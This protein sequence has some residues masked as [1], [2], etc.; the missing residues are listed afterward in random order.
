[1]QG[2]HRRWGRRA[3][4]TVVVSALLAPG[5]AK[6][7]NT[8]C[9]ASG[10]VYTCTG[11]QSAG[12]TMP[13]SVPS[14]AT[15]VTVKSLTS[16][17]SA[18][19]IFTQPSNNSN[20]FLYYTVPYSTAY[21]Y[22][23]AVNGTALKLTALGNTGSSNGSTILYL[24]GWFN[25]AGTST[26]PAILVQDSG[27]NGSNGGFDGG[28]GGN[29]NRSPQS[30]VTLLD[31]YNILYD[32]Y[33]TSSQPGSAAIRSTSTGGNGGNGYY[34]TFVSGGNGGAGG[35]GN[36]AQVSDYYASGTWHLYNESGAAGGAGG[37]NWR[38]RRREGRQRRRQRT[39]SG[40]ER[41]GR[42]RRRQCDL[43]RSI[44]WECYPDNRLDIG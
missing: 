17:I 11:N 33:T 20:F 30:L 16:N 44:K 36:T 26:T 37:D 31:G 28:N 29:A 24:Q 7:A 38:L 4:L 15:Q 23:Y 10:S 2:E 40:R 22:V 14:S 39:L 5:L 32:L 1:M 12:V 42:G 25:P 43:H 6:A 21:P 13:G 35:G 19:S 8:A 3:F 18:P 27:A 9:T 34:G 41:R